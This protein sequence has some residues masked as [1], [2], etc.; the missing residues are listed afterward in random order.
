MQV[1]DRSASVV[2]SASQ[3]YAVVVDVEN[4]P[5]FLP[6][7][8]GSEILETYEDGFSAR[9][10]FSKGVLKKSFS[11]RNTLVKD[12]RITMRLVDGPFSHLQ[13]EWR[14]ERIENTG[15]RVSLHLEFDFSSTPARL[16][17]APV[18][19]TIADHLVGAF[20]ERAREVYQGQDH[21]YD[22]G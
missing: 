19:H 17:L 12:S 13:G 5:T 1:V 6:W 10:D 11:T 2:Y 4:Y 9:V 15:S 8:H 20:A 18:F 16:I 21:D 7:C 14:F 3:M 22:H